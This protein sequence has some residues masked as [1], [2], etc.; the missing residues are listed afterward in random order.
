MGC[1]GSKDDHTVANEKK[2]SPDVQAAKEPVKQSAPKPKPETLPEIEKAPEPMKAEEP[3]GGGGQ[4]DWSGVINEDQALEQACGDHEF[5]T[6]LLTDMAA[7]KENTITEL[8]KA[9]DQNDHDSFR[10]AAHTVKGAALNLALTSIADCGKE[11]E[12]LGK[13]LDK[14]A[15]NADNLTQRQP[16]LDKLQVQFELLD[17]YI[18][19]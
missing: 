11:M 3:Q 5:L 8:Q 14:D 10:T 6:E 13:A 1:G 15:D 2:W 12:I 19:Q 16:W 18:A 17:E 7:E 9:I 4:K